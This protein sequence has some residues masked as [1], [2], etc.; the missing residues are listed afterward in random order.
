[1][2][3]RKKLSSTRRINGSV[4]MG[5]EERQEKFIDFRLSVGCCFVPGE[6][7]WRHFDPNKRSKECQTAITKSI[8]FRARN[9]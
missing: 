4:G 3:E 9:S 6:E 5:G 8:P 1:M 7:P 2:C